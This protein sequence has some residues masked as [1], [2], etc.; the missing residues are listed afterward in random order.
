LATRVR[1]KYP[2]R[3]E[4]GRGHLLGAGVS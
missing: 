4:A 3:A 2:L 1:A